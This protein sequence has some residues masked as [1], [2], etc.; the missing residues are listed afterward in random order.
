[1]DLD[2]MVHREE[3]GSSPRGLGF[4]RAPAASGSEVDV[5]GILGVHRGHGG[6]DGVQTVT[7]E[8]GAWS[9][10]LISSSSGERERLEK[11]PCTGGFGRGQDGLS[12]A[13]LDKRRA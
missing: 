13:S 8:S 7:A 9:S 3:E 6:T 11:L 2:L 5:V 10:S 4:R 1:M 12:A